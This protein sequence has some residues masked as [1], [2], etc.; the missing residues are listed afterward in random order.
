[1]PHVFLG[2]AYGVRKLA[3]AFREILENRAVPKSGS[4][5]PHF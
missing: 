5:L 1:M 4:K 3:C 2:E